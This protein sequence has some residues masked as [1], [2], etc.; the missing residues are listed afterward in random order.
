MKHNFDIEIGK[1]FVQ[2]LYRLFPNESDSKISRRLGCSDTMIS[3]WREGRT[4][5]SGYLS[6]IVHYGA[7][8]MWILIGGNNGNDD[9]AQTQS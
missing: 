5:S 1:R 6:R 2:E 8:V 4:P 9:Q 7:D 3:E